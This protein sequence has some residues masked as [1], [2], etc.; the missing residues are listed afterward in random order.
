MYKDH[1]ANRNT[2]E[3][4]GSSCGIIVPISCIQ[5]CH[6][7]LCI[8]TVDDRVARVRLTSFCYIKRRNR[9][10]CLFGVVGTKGKDLIDERRQEIPTF[11]GRSSISIRQQ[12]DPVIG[13]G[14]KHIFIERSRFGRDIRTAHPHCS[15]FRRNELLVCADPHTK[16]GLILGCSKTDTIPLFLYPC[17]VDVQVGAIG[18]QIV[19]GTQT[20]V[21][22]FGGIQRLVYT[23]A[24]ALHKQFR[25]FCFRSI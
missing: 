18:Q 25:E 21:D 13:Q 14:R 3:R 6:F 10:L 11:I 9:N 15:T 4:A 16:N 1:A 12:T 2:H 19:S 7:R 24:F 5:I 23:N 8:Q 22:R 20:G 17:T